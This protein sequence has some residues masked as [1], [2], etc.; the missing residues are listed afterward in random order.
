MIRTKQGE[1]LVCDEGGRDIC[2]YCDFREICPHRQRH[3]MG[4]LLLFLGVFIGLA[5][6][7]MVCR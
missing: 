2:C 5:V 3:G 1:V 4:W 6:G 7:G